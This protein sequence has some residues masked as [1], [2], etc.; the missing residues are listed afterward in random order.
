MN[1][2]HIIGI[3][4]VLLISCIVIC[5]E[6][7][8]INIATLIKDANFIN[9]FYCVLIFVTLA[10]SFLCESFILVILNYEQNSLIPL[11]GLLL[12]YL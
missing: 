5:K 10:F 2:R 8:T 12:E 7:S 3:L 4:F 11:F 6:L 9:V 1:K